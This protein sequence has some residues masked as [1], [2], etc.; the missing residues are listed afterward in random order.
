MRMVRKI[1]GRR[2]SH[3][4]RYAAGGSLTTS[5]TRPAEVSRVRYAAGGS[6]TSPLRGRRKSHDFRYGRLVAAP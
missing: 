2:K 6:L 3:D 1:E 4:F 5:A